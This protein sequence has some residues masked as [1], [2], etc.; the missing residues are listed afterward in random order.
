MHPLFFIAL[1]ALVSVVGCFLW[2]RRRHRVWKVNLMR[3]PL[4]AEWI[5][6]L[7]E[8]VCL[9]R[10]MPADLKTLLHGYLQVFVAE[11]NFE[12]CGALEAVTD[13]M[14]VTIAG[15]ACLL[16]LGGRNGSYADLH[17]ILIY[18]DD[19][20]PLRRSR[21]GP[22]DDDDFLE[23]PEDEE[24]LLGESWNTGSVLLSWASV[25]EGGR[26]ASDGV[27]VVLHEFAH[28]LDQVNGGIDGA[29]GLADGARHARWAKVMDRAYRRH[30]DRTGG[31]CPTVMDPYG[32]TDP[33]EFFAVCTETF[34]EK[35]RALRRED[36]ALYEELR[37][38][39][40]MD[41]AAWGV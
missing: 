5:G 22:E 41:P 25:L 28:Q 26:N 32:A 20:V 16:L 14:R 23:S 13:E 4:S 1:G 36:R 24:P 38:F 29:P 27:N 11:K 34:F 2:L 30:V 15:Q 19:F 10:R 39:Y 33:G 9:Y 6:I 40:G 21:W 18:G 7:E 3:R 37:D 35:P 8:N 12:A 31:G 17:S